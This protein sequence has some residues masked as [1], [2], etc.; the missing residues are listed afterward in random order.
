MPG[1]AM[2]RVASA[3]CRSL[4]NRPWPAGGSLVHGLVSQCSF[5]RSS[6]SPGTLCSWWAAARAAV[7][8]G[9]RAKA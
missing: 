7:V 8:G 1:H 4:P 2:A 3:A 9:G 6:R 5:S